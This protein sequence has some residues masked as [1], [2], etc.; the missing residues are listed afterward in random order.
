M[1]WVLEVELFSSIRNVA[2][3]GIQIILLSLEK[4]LQKHQKFDNCH[5]LGRS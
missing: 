1:T 4:K 5:F 3:R 2:H